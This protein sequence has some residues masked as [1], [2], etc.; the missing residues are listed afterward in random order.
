MGKF[1]RIRTLSERYASSWV[2]QDCHV[3]GEEKTALKKAAGVS[4]GKDE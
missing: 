4:G 3:A 2:H 1:A